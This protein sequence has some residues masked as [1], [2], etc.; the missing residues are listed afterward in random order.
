[1][2]KKYKLCE[3]GRAEEMGGVAG[4]KNFVIIG[5]G[6]YVKNKIVDIDIMDITTRSGELYTEDQVNAYFKD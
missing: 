6:D 5:I 4:L 3:G 1:M 2:N